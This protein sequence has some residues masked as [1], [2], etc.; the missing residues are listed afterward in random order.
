M[1]RSDDSCHVT[2]PSNLTIWFVQQQYFGI[3]SLKCYICLQYTKQNPKI[4]CETQEK[5]KYKIDVFFIMF[6]VSHKM[7]F[8]HNYVN[9]NFFMLCWTNLFTGIYHIV[10]TISFYLCAY[11]TIFY[12]IC[13]YLYNIIKYKY[14]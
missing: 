9:W 12:R 3:F 6:L 5:W 1:M 10:Q 4:L 14:I 2:A 13:M 8:T 7:H 11:C